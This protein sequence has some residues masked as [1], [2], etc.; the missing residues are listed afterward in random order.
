MK[1]TQLPS[2]SLAPLQV[3]TTP[4]V[5][6]QLVSALHQAVVTEGKGMPWHPA[7]GRALGQRCA[8]DVTA[9]PQEWSGSRE[10]VRRERG[11]RKAP[12]AHNRPLCK[13]AASGD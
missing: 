3:D 13:G 1:S 4:K 2:N 10:L 8:G 9:V 7:A 12:T 11:M 6:I 5:V